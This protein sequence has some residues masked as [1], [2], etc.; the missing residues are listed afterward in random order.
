M[1]KYMT[2]LKIIYYTIFTCLSQVNFELWL[3]LKI[4]HHTF[5]FKFDNGCKNIK[6]KNTKLVQQNMP[7][8]CIQ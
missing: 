3:K 1:G 5:T 2:F 7:G 6:S 8:W 4:T